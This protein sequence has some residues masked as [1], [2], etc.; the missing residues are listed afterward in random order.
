MPMSLLTPV[1]EVKEKKIEKIVK[2]EV[3]AEKKPKAN[4]EVVLEKEEKP[5]KI[6]KAKASKTLKK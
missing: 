2:N 5:K 4:A 1:V 3:V 6:V